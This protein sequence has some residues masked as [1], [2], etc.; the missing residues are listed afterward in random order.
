MRHKHI[1]FFKTSL[2]KKHGD[3]LAGSVFAALMLFFDS[4][5]AAAKTSF[6]S[7]CYKLADFFFLFAHYI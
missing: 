2:V 4:F 1:E 5:F 3:A 7:F 6:S